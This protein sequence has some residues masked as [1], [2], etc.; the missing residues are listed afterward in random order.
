MINQ[1]FIQ[2]PPEPLIIDSIILL[3]WSSLTDKRV[4][5]RTD[6]DTQDISTKFTSIINQLRQ[7]YLPCKQ[8]KY[9][10]SIN[11]KSII[12]IVRQLLKT[13][14]YTIRGIERVIENKKEMTYKLEPYI[15]AKCETPCH[16]ITELTPNT[17][18]NNINTITKQTKF[19]VSWN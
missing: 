16:K 19:I 6:L 2:K 5:L 17:L 11:T 12:T 9:L 7:Y 1:L 15:K 14:G 3:G 8:N 18:L 10:S 4:L 13:I